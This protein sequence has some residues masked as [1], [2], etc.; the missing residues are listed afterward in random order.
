MLP[1]FPSI[2]ERNLHTLYGTAT[3]QINGGYII[4]SNSD[5]SPKGSV[6][7]KIR[8]LVDLINRHSDYVTL[9]SCSGRV[10][11]FDPSGNSAVEDARNDDT[12]DT[13]DAFNLPDRSTNNASADGGTIGDDS[14]SK[15]HQQNTTGGTKIS[16]KG[17]GKWIFVTH[18]ILPDLDSRIIAALQNVGWND[19]MQRD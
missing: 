14:K 19:C 8:P 1:S 16:G 5:K 6:D 7:V 4:D 18:D 17:R 13:T 2:R 11:L 10:A 9:S 12:Q 15:Q 3:K